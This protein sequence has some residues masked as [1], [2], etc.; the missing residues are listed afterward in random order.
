MRATHI[1]ARGQVEFV[2]IPV[3]EAGPGMA[4]VRPLMWAICGSDVR[5]VFYAPEE[6]YPLTAGQSGHEIIAQVEAINGQAEG[7]AVGDVVLALRPGDVGMCEYFVTEVENLLPLPKSRSFEESLMAQQLGTVIFACKR[8]P[9]LLGLNAAVVIG[10]GSAGLF[11]DA[12]LR[13]LGVERVIAV[14]VKEARLAAGLRFGATD[15]IHGAQDD[16]LAAVTALTGGQ[17][18]DLV[19]EAAGEPETINLMPTLVRESGLLLSFGIPR[20]PH[21]F[22]L[23]YYELFRKKAHLLSSDGTAAEPGRKSIRMALDLVGRGEIDVSGMVTH[24]FPFERVG[25][26]YELARSREDRAIKVVVQRSV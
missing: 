13:R 24:R 8:L 23:N 19:V 18:A 12:M 5:L 16:P 14:D 25:E 26:A 7:V 1:V 4:L 9:S 3:P 15:V 6:E 10:Q 22:A 2:D 11:F 20:G 17:L 21:T